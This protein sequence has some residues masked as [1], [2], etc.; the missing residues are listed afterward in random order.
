MNLF[1]NAVSSFHPVLDT[2]LDD[3]TDVMLTVSLKT[4]MIVELV[5]AS[6]Q[7]VGKQ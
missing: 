6:C 4:E 3:N 1:K 5:S 7:L 2:R